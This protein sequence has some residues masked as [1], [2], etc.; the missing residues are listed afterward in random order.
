MFCKKCGAE[1]P[2]GKTRCPDCG[3]L[4]DGLKF[5]QHCGEA[6]DKECVICPRCGKQ[7]GQIKAEQPNIVINNSNANT[8][9]NIN[10]MGGFGRAK[11]KWAAFFLCLFLGFFGAHKF[12]EDKIGMGIIYLFTLGLF[13][14]GWFIDLVIL[15]FKPTIYFV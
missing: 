12:Y 7:V 9:T 4:R 10:H 6:I 14:I 1:I 11:N 5:C 15:L 2:A 8:N 13:G 3:A